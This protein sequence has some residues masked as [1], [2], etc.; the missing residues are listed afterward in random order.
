LGVKR[1]SAVIV[2][3]SRFHRVQRF[4]FVANWDFRHFDLDKFKIIAHNLLATTD[5]HS[6]ARYAASL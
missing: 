6:E 5:W 3:D 2:V 4:N 1:T